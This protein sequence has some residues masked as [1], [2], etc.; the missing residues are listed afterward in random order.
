M[1]CIRGRSAIGL[2]GDH[3]AALRGRDSSR[4]CCFSGLRQAP[5]HTASEEKLFVGG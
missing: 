2:R 1:I 3:S 5:A 4:A